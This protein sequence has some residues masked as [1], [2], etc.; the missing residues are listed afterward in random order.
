MGAG[1]PRVPLRAASGQRGAASAATMLKGEALQGI[2]GDVD[3]GLLLRGLEFGFALIAWTVMSAA[4]RSGNAGYFEYD[5]YTPL[6][7]VLAVGIIH[8]GYIIS[9]V[10]LRLSR[11]LDP[12]SLDKF[13]LY[14]T[15]LTAAMGL[16]AAVAGSAS[17]TQLHDKF[18]SYATSV[19]KPKPHFS[20][21]DKAKARYFCE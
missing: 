10:A 8:W 1:P 3:L 18:G 15:G 16:I 20:S 6:N 4:H 19:C 13:E 11:S 2:L 17:S 12:P 9:L 7:F 21:G 14:G 5:N